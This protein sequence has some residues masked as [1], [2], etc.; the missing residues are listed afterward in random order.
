[1]NHQAEYEVWRNMIRRCTRETHP[2]YDAYGARGISVCR[3][4]MSFETFIRD[5]GERPSPSHSLDRFDNDG[6]Y[7]P[8]NC[9]W[10]TAE[11]QNRNRRN[12]R[13]ITVDDQTMLLSEWA[14][15]AGVHPSTI[16]KR[17]K[18]GWGKAAAVGLSPKPRR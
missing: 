11:Q 10:A 8:G 14:E 9:R 16:H 7:C 3:E 15:L 6:D 2:D 4:W 5:M 13:W 1:M 18:R 12:N 17:L